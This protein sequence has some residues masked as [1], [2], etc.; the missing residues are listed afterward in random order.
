[1]SERARS[2]WVLAVALATSSSACGDCSSPQ[3]VDPAE[4]S[5]TSSTKSSSIATSAGPATSGSS[6]GSTSGAGGAGSWLEDPKLW[7]PIGGAVEETCEL[8]QAK[9]PSALVPK[10]LWS[11]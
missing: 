7:Q 11:P 8:A 3:D 10:R 6:S 2:V 5:A 4:P 9:L 1:M